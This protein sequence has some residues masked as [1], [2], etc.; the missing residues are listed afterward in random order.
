MATLPEPGVW[1]RSYYLLTLGL[2]LTVAATAFEALAIATTLPATVRELGGLAL[3]GWAFSAFMLTNLVGITLAGGEADR[4]GPARPFVIGVILFALGLLISGFAPA[5]LVV[6][7]GRGVQ[8]FGAGAIASVAYVAIGRGFPEAAKARMLALLSSAW[9]VPGLIGPALA[10]LIG[11]HLGWR[12]VFLLL[13]PL[14]PLAACLALPALRHLPGNPKAIRDWQRIRASVRLPLGVAM[15]VVAVELRSLPLVA[16]LAAVGLVLAI[17]ALHRLLPAGTLR[18]KAGLP[19]A[20]AT[21]GLLNLGFFGAD[22]FVPLALR[23][24]RGQTGTAAGLALTAATVCWSTGSWIQARLAAGG[25][26]RGRV[27]LGQAFIAIGAAGIALVVTT[28]VPVL[29][30]VVAWGIAGLG[31]G[32]AF[33]TI[34]LVVLEQALPGQEGTTSSAMQLVSGLGTALGTG[35]GGAVIAY[36]SIANTT[37]RTGILIQDLLMIGVLMIGIIAA[38]GLPTDPHRVF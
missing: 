26:G 30:A 35:L 37:P 1:S 28:N 38:L 19:A 21:M 14:A 11:D 18:A 31:M 10:G 7:I 29:L 36:F 9:V 25:G 22:A 34:S 24:V 32:L 4:Y 27:M 33:S 16:L 2:I 17:P 20:I 15:I 6:I 12:W 23:N 8:G 5:M 3:Y 13:A